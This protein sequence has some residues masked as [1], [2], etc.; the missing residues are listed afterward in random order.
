[1]IDSVDALE[2]TRIVV[3]K[4]VDG[5]T[6]EVSVPLADLGLTLKSGV[7]LRGDFGVTFGNQAGDR[8]R[9]RNY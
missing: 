3:T 9:L 5:Y 8:T 2:R 6:V 4:R 1:M 7:T